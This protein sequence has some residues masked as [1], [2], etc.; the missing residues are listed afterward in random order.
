MRVHRTLSPT[1][2]RPLNS[3]N[4]EPIS[5]STRR[6]EFCVP[7]P[8]PLSPHTLCSALMEN[9]YTGDALPRLSLKRKMRRGWVGHQSGLHLDYA[10]RRECI[11]IY[12]ERHLTS[13]VEKESESAA[14]DGAIG[15]CARLG[16]RGGQSSLDGGSDR[17]PFHLYCAAL[18]WCAL[19]LI[20]PFL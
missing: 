10:R 16:V 2:G 13:R 1:A 18:Q 4:L 17:P 9:S 8:F 19:V 11:Y 15:W 20:P 5:V 6:G 3:F 14:G 7:A 12:R